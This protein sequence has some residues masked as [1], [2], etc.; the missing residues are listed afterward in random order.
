MYI[1][2]HG[3]KYNKVHLACVFEK[4]G[5]QRP[6]F[7]GLAS[8]MYQIDLEGDIKP[9]NRI[10]ISESGDKITDTQSLIQAIKEAGG[11]EYSTSILLPLDRV[12]CFSSTIDFSSYDQ[13]AKLILVGDDPTCSVFMQYPPGMDLVFIGSSSG[14]RLQASI[15]TVKELNFGVQVGSVMFS[16][17]LF[18]KYDYNIHI[19]SKYFLNVRRNDYTLSVLLTL[20]CLD[21]LSYTQINFSS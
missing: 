5:E 16:N 1:R 14:R 12:D 11:D 8:K 20:I 18:N 4:N 15:D 6:P 3:D 9:V 7:A 10:D 19:G 21:C 17:N 2:R 13:L